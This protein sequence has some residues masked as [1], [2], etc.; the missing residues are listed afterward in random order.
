MI[1]TFMYSEFAVKGEFFSESF[2]LWLKSPNKGA[3]NY[4][5]RYP[6]KEKMLKTVIWHF[7]MEDLCQCEKGFEIESLFIDFV[8]GNNPK[9]VLTLIKENWSLT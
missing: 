4:P 5:E 1:F 2:S 3:K 8:A 9:I 7:F 6:A